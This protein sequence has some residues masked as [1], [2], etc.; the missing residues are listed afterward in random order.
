[1][2]K[3]NQGKMLKKFWLTLLFWLIGIFIL[4]LISRLFQIKI[5]AVDMLISNLIVIGLILLIN[6]LYTKEKIYF[7]WFGMRRI[8]W[9]WLFMPVYIVAI[10]VMFKT[11]P[12]ES[13]LRISLD[14]MFWLFYTL[15]TSSIP[16]V[17]FFGVLLPAMMHEWKTENVVTKSVVACSTLYSVF[18]IFLLNDL[19]C[20]VLETIYQLVAAF[21][22]GLVCALLYLRSVNIIVPLFFSFIEAFF[23]VILTHIAP[24][25]G[26]G[27]VNIL[28][29]ILFAFLVIKVILKPSAIQQIQN[30]FAVK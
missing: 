11:I 1:M 14:P 29:F 20:G 4:H 10:N 16:V 23:A 8:G 24:L 25:F 2:E 3:Q 9:L 12:S 26:S 5:S 19:Y 7:K 28:F 6:W 18:Q 17:T 21:S 15:S 13:S 22:L 27:I 30:D